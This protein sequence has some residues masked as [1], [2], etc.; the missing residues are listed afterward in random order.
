[1]PFV[2]MIKASFA[3]DPPSTRPNPELHD[4][5]EKAPR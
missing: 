5:L 1:V 3:S 2:E 4:A